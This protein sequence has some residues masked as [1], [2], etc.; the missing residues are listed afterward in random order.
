[1]K[2]RDNLI[3]LAFVVGILLMEGGWVGLASNLNGYFGT[4]VGGLFL[5]IDAY[6]INFVTKSDS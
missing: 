6:F 1:M 4:I 2:T 3:G 5:A